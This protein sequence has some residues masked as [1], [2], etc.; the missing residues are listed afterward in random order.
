M[1][2]LMYGDFW[3]STSRPVFKLNHCTGKR[4][5]LPQKIP[6]QGKHMDLRHVA[7]TQGKL[8]R[9][10]IAQGNFPVGQGETQEICK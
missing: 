4:G 2:E 10:G 1:Q 9:Q 6:C 3:L 7:K 5:K 8:K